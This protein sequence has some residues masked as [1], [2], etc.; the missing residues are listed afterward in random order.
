MALTA[1]AVVAGCGHGGKPVGKVFGESLA[2]DDLYHDMELYGT[3]IQRNVQITTGTGRTADAPLAQPLTF[4]ALRTAII[5]RATIAVAKDDGVAPTQADIDRELRF[6]ND[7]TPGYLQSMTKSGLTMSRVKSMIEVQLA[8][9]DLLTEGVHVSREDALAF[10]KAHPEQ[11][12]NPET[13]TVLWIFVK[14]ATSEAEVNKQLLQGEPF[15]IVASD[16]SEIPGAK[17]SNGRFPVSVVKEMD[18]VVPGLSKVVENTTAGTASEWLPIPG[19]GFGK[20]DVVEKKA[21]APMEWDDSKTEHLRRT[22][23]EDR[24][25]QGKEPEL[26][27]RI[28]D[29][30]ASAKAD[31]LDIQDS[32][33][34]QMW[35][36]WLDQQKA[37]IT[38]QTSSSTG[39]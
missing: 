6:R 18:G 28:F 24:G 39:K 22:M 32:A 20:F 4:Q 8:E 13:A 36:D 34:K 3:P 37:N 27:R 35:S 30:I 2:Q 19:G 1:M 21:A 11:F 7:L 31:Q 10:K 14:K 23:A 9:E 33:L 25:R 15:N 5:R 12:M 16:M 17:Q 26:D 29:K 38:P